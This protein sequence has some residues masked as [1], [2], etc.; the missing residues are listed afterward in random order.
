MVVYVIL[1]SLSVK[2]ICNKSIALSI[3]F[4]LLQFHASEDLVALNTI[5][6]N[7]DEDFED[8]P[9]PDPLLEFEVVELQSAFVYEACPQ[10]GNITCNTVKPFFIFLINHVIITCDKKTLINCDV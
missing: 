9:D 2:S 10:K 5:Y 4:Y 1:W 7:L 6:A 3:L 8:I